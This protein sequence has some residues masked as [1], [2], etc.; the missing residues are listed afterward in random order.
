MKIH[1]HTI[2]SIILLIFFFSAGFVA[3][4]FTGEVIWDCQNCN[5]D[6]GEVIPVVNDEYADVLLKEI[7]NAKK[8]IHIVMYS[9]KFYETNNSVRQIEDALITAKKRGVDVKI[10]LDQSKWSG[11]ITSV[12][13]NN[14]VVKEYLEQNG[15]KV[16]FDSMKKTTH[17]KMIIIDKKI[18]LIGSTNWTY[19]ALERNNEANVLIKDEG[20]AK[21]F[22]NYFNFLWKN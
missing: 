8:S 10:I 4:S 12:S 1:K 6:N 7:N 17:V 9:S 18:V 5:F 16:K 20:I 19:S 13:K 2:F 14:E 11:Q 22:T 3:S 21:Y 15:I